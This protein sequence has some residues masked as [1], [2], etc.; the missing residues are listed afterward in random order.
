MHPFVRHAVLLCLF[1]TP[2]VAHAD[3][4]YTSSAAFRAANPGLTTVTFD[5]IA[6]S[7]GF[8]NEGTHFTLGGASFVSSE[9]LDI[10]SADYYAIHQPGNG[11][12]TYDSG[13]Y[14]GGTNGSVETLT[15]NIGPSNAIGLNLGGEYLPQ[16]FSIV[17]SDGFSQI[18]DTSNNI[19]RTGSL[20]FVGLTSSSPLT[21]ITITELAAPAGINFAFDNVSYIAP[22]TTAPTPEPS[23][24]LLLAT[25]LVGVAGAARR[26]LHR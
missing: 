26:R 16:S 5:N 7:G 8:V 10:N 17:L 24:L 23:S 4:V 2:F 13:G 15:I 6:A 11:F 12:K 18:F 9:Y 22:L 21:S 3:T 14:L 19:V 1:A 25:G 20:D